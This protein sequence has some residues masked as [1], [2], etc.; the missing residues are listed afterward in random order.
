MAKNGPICG[1]VFKIRVAKVHK[2]F[3]LLRSDAS[4][5]YILTHEMFTRYS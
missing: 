3:L 2:M 5:I 4:V 1:N